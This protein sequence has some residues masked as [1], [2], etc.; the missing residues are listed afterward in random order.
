MYDKPLKHVPNIALPRALAGNAPG[1]RGTEVGD[2]LVGTLLLQNDQIVGMTRAPETDL[3]RILFP[4]PVEAHA[5]LDKC[6][7][8]DRIKFSGGDLAAAIQAQHDDKANWSSGDLRARAS[9]GLQEAVDAGCSAL[10]SHVDWGHTAQAPLAWSVLNEL[11]QQ[12]DEFLQLAALTGIDQLADEGMAAKIARQISKGHALGSFVLHHSSA[13]EGIRNAFVLADQFG[14]LL[15]F[16]VDETTDPASNGLEIIADTALEMRHQGPILCGHAVSLSYQTED[17]RKRI[18]EKLARANIFV[19]ALPATN[20][21]LQGRD[22]SIPTSRGLTPLNELQNAG[23][24]VVVGT[25]NV[26]DAFCPVGRHDPLRSLELAVLAGHLEPPMDR[27]L[28]TT[29]TNARAAIGVGKPV[30]A[31]ASLSDFRVAEASDLNQLI[32]GATHR[33]A[34]TLLEELPQ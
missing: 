1:F 6:H 30:L 22:G 17:I 18:I 32:S 34:S 31:G 27:W 9:R 28:A 20:L 29:T 13:K 4:A 7:T 21:Y 19:A 2:T 24:P 14:L 10:R 23:V 3:T 33:P 26:R 15:D 8:I 11:S 25:D 16:H 5:H 12:S